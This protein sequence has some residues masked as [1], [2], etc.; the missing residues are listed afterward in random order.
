MNI[1]KNVALIERLKSGLLSDTAALFETLLDKNSTASARKEVL[2]AILTDVYLL[3][4]KLNIGSSELDSAAVTRL[5]SMD[6]PDLQAEI[7]VLLG[8]IK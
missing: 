5:R 3:A 1:V 2:A 6:S 8:K 4:E 7:Q